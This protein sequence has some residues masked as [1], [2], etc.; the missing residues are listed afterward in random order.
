MSNIKVNKIASREGLYGPTISGVS[1]VSSTGAMRVPSGSKDERY[2][3]NNE[4]IPRENLTLYVDA[5][6]SYDEKEPSTWWDMSGFNHHGELRGPVFS[7][8]NE[9]C[10]TFDGSNDDVTFSTNY[11]GGLG[12]KDQYT[13][14][15]WFRFTS[16]NYTAGSGRIDFIYTMV[17]SR[18][19]LTFDREGDGKIGN[20]I[21]KVKSLTTSSFNDPKTTTASWTQNTWYNI[22]VTGR[23]KNPFRDRIYVNGVL[24]NSFSIEDNNFM[25][26]TSGGVNSGEGKYGSWA[27]GKTGNANPSSEFYLSGYGSG[28]TYFPGQIAILAL[29]DRELSQSEVLQFYNTYKSRF[30]Y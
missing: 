11:L 12:A 24:E 7:T 27:T 16:G 20:Y 6:Y 14:S 18:P 19:H 30:G 4:E 28:S 17:N 25:N 1:T 23:S 26:R 13:Q 8:D 5:K 22:T 9:G 21:T 10:F 3:D 2:V 15:I 29:Y